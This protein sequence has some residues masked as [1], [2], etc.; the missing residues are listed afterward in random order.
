MD[1]IQFIDFIND[2]RNTNSCF[3]AGTLVVLEDF[4]ERPIEELAPGNRVRTHTGRIGTVAQ[5][6]E[7]PYT[8]TLYEIQVQSWIYPLTATAEHPFAVV[9]NVSSRAKHGS[10]EAGPLTWKKASELEPGDYVLLPANLNPADDSGEVV[11]RLCDYLEGDFWEAEGKIR[12]YQGRRDS[13][14]PATVPFDETFGRLLGLFL[15]EGSFLKPSGTLQGLAFTFA[16]EEQDLHNFVIFALREIFGVV[17]EL[18]EPPSR[19][20][21]SRVLAYN[22]TLAQVFHNLCGEGALN[23][24]VPTICFRAPL[25]VRLSVLRGWF[26][27]DG[28]S[29][30]IRFRT[31]KD[32]S[33]RKSAGVQ[34][35]TSSKVLHR[36]LFRLASISGVKLSTQL[37]KEQEH[38]NAPARELNL[39]GKNILRVFPEAEKLLEEHDVTIASYSWY[40]EHDLGFLCRVREVNVPE[41]PKNFR[42][43]NLEVEGDHTYIAEGVAVHNCV[44]QSIQQQ[45]FIAQ[46][47]HGIADRKP[48]SVMFGYW[49]TRNR[50]GTEKLDLGCFPRLAWQA[51]KGMG[52]CEEKMWAFDP[53]DIN[54]PP[55]FDATAAAIDQQWIEGYYNIWGLSGRAEEVRSAISQG[56]PVIFGTIVD[57]DFKRYKGIK[58]PEPLK[59]PKGFSGRHMMCAVA[60]DQDGLWVLNSWGKDWGASDPSGFHS[61]GFFRM[62]WEW[63]AWHQVTDWWAVKIPKEFVK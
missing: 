18:D 28:S 27:G 60:Y 25:S 35:V 22:S 38:Q 1:M 62:S 44:W 56:H 5:C 29:S 46:G 53:A 14:L 54:R 30:P 6:S 37:R 26:E 55:D 61:G 47:V 19:K 36:S 4:T 11:L 13:E 3:P 58:N 8:G 63:V 23:K 40:K 2:Q 33:I 17:G 32:G 15:A 41:T 21:T 7:R 34:G 43:Y 52:F 51:T 24:Y 48:L 49:H 59:P 57:D 45:H 9:P 12:A 10:F 31:K 20:S 50:G 42:V 39:Y 16:R